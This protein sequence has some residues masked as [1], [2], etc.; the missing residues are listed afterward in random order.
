MAP[1]AELALPRLASRRRQL[2]RLAAEAARS[3]TDPAER[4]YWLQAAEESWRASS[5][6]QRKKAPRP[7]A[8]QRGP[9]ARRVARRQRVTSGLRRARAPGSSGDDGSSEG[10][11]GPAAHSREPLDLLDAVALSLGW[12]RV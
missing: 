10:E 7:R 3:E 8:L 11:S 4:E 9:R 6:L 2:A 5:L 12:A 1:P